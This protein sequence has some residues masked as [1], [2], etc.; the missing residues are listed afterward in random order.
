MV[1]KNVINKASHR[2]VVQKDNHPL[3]VLEDE[4]VD[5]L[6][7]GLLGPELYQ[8]CQV[9]QAFCNHDQG[10]GGCRRWRVRD[11]VELPRVQ[12]C[13]AKQPQEDES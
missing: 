1:Y 6:H 4:R 5:H 7:V 12:D 9:L 2:K 8:I 10:S 3:L 11:Q 13:G